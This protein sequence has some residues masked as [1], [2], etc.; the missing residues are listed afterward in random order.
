MKYLLP[1]FLASS[2]FGASKLHHLYN[3]WMFES[4]TYGINCQPFDI[5]SPQFTTGLFGSALDCDGTLNSAGPAIGTG[6]FAVHQDFTAMVWFNS[7]TDS[8]NLVLMDCRGASPNRGFTVYH[9][10]D[11][12]GGGTIWFRFFNG[13]VTSGTFSTNSAPTNQ[14]NCVLFGYNAATQIPFVRL[15]DGQVDGS[16]FV[17]SAL[18]ISNIAIGARSIHT[19]PAVFN[20]AID[21][22]SLWK[23]KVLSAKEMGELY[24]GGTGVDYPYP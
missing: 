24:N 4:N 13:G 2:L 14:W 12:A 18:P 7:R 22:P 17:P 15:N 11:N 23:G 10:G 16:V 21:L 9:V 20:G 5:A 8:N 19:D 3:A 6:T 1:L